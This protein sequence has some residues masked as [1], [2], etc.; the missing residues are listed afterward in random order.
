[1]LKYLAETEPKTP[2]ATIYTS[3]IKHGVSVLMYT[4]FLTP[5][6]SSLNYSTY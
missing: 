2:G 3:V 1:V 4:N 5:K 6:T